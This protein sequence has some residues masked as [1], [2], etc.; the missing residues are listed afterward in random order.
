MYIVKNAWRNVTRNKGRNILIGIIIMVIALSSCVALAIMNT[1]SK[2]IESYQ[3]K[4]DITATIGVNRSNMMKDFNSTSDTNKDDL[5]E[6]FNN[7]SSLTTDEIESYADSKYVSSYYYTNSIGLDGDGLDPASTQKTD[8]TNS[9]DKKQAPDG[10]NKGGMPGASTTDFKL[11]G[12][13]SLEAMSD[14]INGTYKISDGNISED[15]YTCVINSELAELNNISVG[16]TIKLTDDDDNTYKLKVTG[17]FTE[18]SESDQ[19]SMFSNSV[20]NIITTT[21]TISKIT[22]K[23]SDITSTLSPTFVLTSKDVVSD[24]EAE[25]TSKGLDENLKVQTNLDQIENS[26]STIDNVKTFATTFLIIVLIIGCIVLLVINAIN[27]RERKYEIGVLRTIGMKKSALAMQMMIELVMVSF[28][29]LIMGAVVGSL[30]SVPVSN[31]L[32]SSEISSNNEERTN[33]GNNFGSQNHDFSKVSGVSNL[34]E[35]KTI[36]AAVDIKVLA[37]L[38]GIGLVIT[39][40]SSLTAMISIQKFSPL[41][42]LKE[43]S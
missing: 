4:Y 23:N 25:L 15:D 5:V 22:T 12:Y 3:N 16:D 32:L 31:Q 18:T 2:L 21:N 36:D 26:T 6:K 41:T 19:M 33:I 42:I 37:E 11:V 20:N 13:S 17:I 34:T 14:F 1:S 27:I 35:I 7:I 9:D 30:I 38:L 40:I 28:F 43:R 8:S 24:F 39:I 10:M 29:A